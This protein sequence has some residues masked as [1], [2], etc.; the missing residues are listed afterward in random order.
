MSISMSLVNDSHILEYICKLCNKSYGR[1][2][3]KNIVTF[4]VEL[5]HETCSI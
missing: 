2:L 4:L 5:D 3:Y 1:L